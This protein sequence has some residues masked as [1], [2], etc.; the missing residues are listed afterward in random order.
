M[1]YPKLKSQDNCAFPE[2]EICNYDRDKGIERCEYM[3]YDNLAS[4]FD[5]NRWKC[6]YNLSK[7]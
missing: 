5:P 3:Y 1:K 2:R 4:P 6:K 7:G